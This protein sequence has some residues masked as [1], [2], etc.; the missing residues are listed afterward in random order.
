MAGGMM[1]PG[2][3]GG[4]K[5]L[6]AQL[7]LVPFIDLL[8]CCISFLLITAV[9]VTNSRIPA[10]AQG[11][12]SVRLADLWAAPATRRVLEDARNEPGYEQALAVLDRLK[13]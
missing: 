2:G 10:D 5:P 8:S 12:V 11:F 4:R 13:P 7:N 3:K 6:D 1:V 9:W